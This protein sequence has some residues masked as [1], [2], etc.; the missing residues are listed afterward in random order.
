MR[1]DDLNSDNYP[2]RMETT[3]TKQI[4]TLHVFPTDERE[5][6]YFLVDKNLLH[7]CSTEEN[8][9][10]V[11]IADEFSTK[12]DEWECVHKNISKQKDAIK[13]TEYEESSVTYEVTIYF[14]I[15]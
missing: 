12:E 14:N 6:K 15:L 13:D 4:P 10:K 11:I 3:F 9:S 2:V 1:A 5:L 8:E 7:I